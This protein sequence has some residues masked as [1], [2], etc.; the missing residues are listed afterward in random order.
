MELSLSIREA[1]A[2]LKQRNM[3]MLFSLGLM[4]LNSWTWIEL[5]GQE[6]KII[7]IPTLDSEV[8]ISNK[9]VSADY[10]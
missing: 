2:V 1:Q 4:V 7:L 10:L 6:E 9:G 5:R 8:M 3:L